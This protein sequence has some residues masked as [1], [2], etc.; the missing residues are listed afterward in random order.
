ANSGTMVAR[1][2]SVASSVTEARLTS[3]VVENPTILSFHHVLGG[4]QGGSTSGYDGGLLEYSINGGS[5]WASVPAE[6]FLTGGYTHTFSTCCSNP[7]PS[8]P[9]WAGSIPTM[10]EVRIDLTALQ[11]ESA[12]FR[13]VWVSDSSITASLGWIIDD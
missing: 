8:A 12:Q 13:W 4:E 2:T 3:P 7:R 6:W 11:G 1:Y 10:S 9:G 5:T